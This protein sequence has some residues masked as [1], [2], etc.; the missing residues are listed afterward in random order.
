MKHRA[1]VTGAIPKVGELTQLRPLGNVPQSTRGLK[2]VLRWAVET[3]HGY[4]KRFWESVAA[5]CGRWLCALVRSHH[6]AFEKGGTTVLVMAPFPWLETLG[7]LTYVVLLP[8]ALNEYLFP[9]RWYARRTNQYGMRR[10]ITTKR[11]GCTA[12][13][14][15]F[16]PSFVLMI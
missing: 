3:M 14:V 5:H 12:G 9:G 7:G 15:K 1:R 10:R 4:L 16:G 6:L 2:I 13:C 11:P 8:S